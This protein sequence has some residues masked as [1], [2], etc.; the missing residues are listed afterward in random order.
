MKKQ[1]ILFIA[2]LMFICQLSVAQ[3]LSFGPM[4]GVNFSTLSG[5]ENTKSKTGLLAGAFLNYSSKNWFGLGVQ[6]LYNQAGASLVTPVESVNLNYLQIPILATYYFGEGNKTGSF[7]P[8]LFAGPHVNFLLNAQNKDG[9]DLNPEGKFYKNSDLGLTFGGGFNYALAEKTWLNFDV[10]YGLGL[11]NIA[12][13]GNIDIMNR[14]LG[15]TLGVS[16]P[17]GNI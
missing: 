2:T 14:G 10:R 16:F 9:N 3:N 1:S 7:R 12:Q 4:A 11:T 13:Q 8:K 5:T 17:L 6:V 15:F